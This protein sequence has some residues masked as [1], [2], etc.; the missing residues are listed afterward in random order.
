MNTVTNFL[1][2]VGAVALVIWVIHILSQKRVRNAFRETFIDS[3]RKT[4]IEDGVRAQN[5][6]ERAV[7]GDDAADAL[8]VLSNE[9]R[10]SMQS[11][12]S[13]RPMP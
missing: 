11:L 3:R 4:I 8:A 5:R 13:T 9:R 2:I 12:R 1:A 6:L 10:K 7:T